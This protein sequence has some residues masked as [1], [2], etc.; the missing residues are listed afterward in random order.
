M[1]YRKLV[2]QLLGLIIIAQMAFGQKREIKIVGK[3]ILRYTVETIKAKPGET[4]KITLTTVSKMD[5]SQMAHNWVL[6]KPGT[7]A[8]N[9]VTKDLQHP[10]TDYIDPA[11]SGKVIAKS[12]MLGDG[13]TDSV[14]F[15]VPEKKG[16][17]EY[18]CTFRAH[19]QAGMK[20]RLIVE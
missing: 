4:L 16:E 9:F 18:V 5:K 10:K 2:L 7:D 17:Y 19:Y 6:L 8:L 14:T 12:D 11:M 20:G 13:E 1:I 15:L 3:D